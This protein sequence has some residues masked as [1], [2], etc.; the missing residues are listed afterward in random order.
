VMGISLLLALGLGFGGTIAREAMDLRLR[1]VRAFRHLYK[2]PILGFIPVF[3]DERFHRERT[4]R[5]AAVFGGLITFTMVFSIFLLVYR[6]KI[7][8]ILNF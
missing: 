6:D 3:Q 2:V 8:T 1:D 5:R 4:V 7:R